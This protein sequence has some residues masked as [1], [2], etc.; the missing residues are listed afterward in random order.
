VF[1]DDDRRVLYDALET[2]L[3]QPAAG[4]LMAPLP[5]VGW[6]DVATRADLAA[7]R[8]ELRG[9]MAEMRGEMAKMAARIDG[10]IP[11]FVAANLAS[12][13]GLA[14]IL[15]GAATLLR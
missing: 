3:G 12:M 8:T 1:T 6:G 13:I 10:L 4:L 9:E 2:S 15:I 11:K 7:M 5:P 14:G